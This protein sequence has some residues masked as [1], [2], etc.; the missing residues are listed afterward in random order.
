MLQRAMLQLPSIARVLLPSAT[1]GVSVLQAAAYSSRSQ[2]YQSAWSSKAAWAGAAVAAVTTA[3]VSGQNHTAHAD[4]APQATIQ[5]PAD[6]YVL[7]APTGRVPKSI[8]VYQYEVCPFC[9]KVKTFLDYHKMPYS[10]VEVN[11]ITKG[12]LSWTSYRKVPVVKL[13]DDVV[14]DSSAIIS[15]LQAE[16]NAA[17]PAA[18]K[19]G[20]LRGKQSGSTSAGSRADEEQWRKWVDERFVKVLTA[21]IYRTWDE[22]WSTTSYMAEQSS[23]NWGVRQG[24][25]VAGALLMWQIGQRMPKKYNI[26]GDL[27]EALYADANKFIAAVGS[28]SF[29]GGAKPNLA[30]LAMFGV[31]SAIRGTDTYND[32][33]LNSSIGQWLGRMAQTVGDSAEVKH[34]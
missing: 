32:L 18:A 24:V 20:W 34:V 31:L 25:R 19:G 4:A 33:I 2:Q 9:C 16:L 30:D 17:E 14:A 23:W 6:P 13:D 5:P 11:P 26:E 15:R 10:T 22:S 27:R 8:I 3:A 7:P 21:N 1:Q 29:M 12:E 28:Q